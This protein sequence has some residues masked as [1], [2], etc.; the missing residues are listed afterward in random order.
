VYV[1]NDGYTEAFG[2]HRKDVRSGQ[3]LASLLCGML[4]WFIARRARLS[5]VASVAGGLVCAT[6]LWIGVLLLIALFAWPTRMRCPSC[7]RKRFVEESNC[8]HCHEGWSPPVRTGTEIF[9][10][11]NETLHGS[12]GI[13]QEHLGTMR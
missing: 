8:R 2:H 4:G 7:G 1:V 13:S 5:V 10:N 12:D 11:L 6:L 9:E 3:I